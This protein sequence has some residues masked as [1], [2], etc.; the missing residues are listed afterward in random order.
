[1]WP[2]KSIAYFPENKDFQCGNLLHMFMHGGFMHIFFQYVCVVFFWLS[3]R[4]NLGGSKNFI[5]YISCGLGALL[6]TAVNYYYFQ[7]DLRANRQWISNKIFYK[8]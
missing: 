3:I 8:Y 4:T 2:I 5:F 6:H 1:M 7:D